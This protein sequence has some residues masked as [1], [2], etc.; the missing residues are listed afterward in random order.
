VR[1]R[2]FTAY[3]PPFPVLDELARR[4]PDVEID[5]TFD[6]ELYGDGRAQWRGGELVQYE[7]EI[8]G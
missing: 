7:D 5:L 3:N 2:F 8:P 4:F 6:V 1:Y